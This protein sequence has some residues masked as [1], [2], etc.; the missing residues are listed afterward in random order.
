MCVDHLQGRPEL[1][2]EGAW[3]MM[4]SP[5][6]PPTYQSVLE[7][8]NSNDVVLEIGAGDLRLSHSMALISKQVYAI[9]IQKDIL[10]QHKQALPKNLTIF[11]GDARTINFPPDISVGVILMR[12]CM[13]LQLYAEKLKSSGCKRII[14]NARW[15]LGVEE[16]SL[17]IVRKPYYLLE[18]GWYACWCGAAGFKPGP[19]EH[20]S[21]EMDSIVNEVV[22]CPQCKPDYNLGLLQKAEAVTKF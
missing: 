16:I 9:E 1:Q 15:R 7:K 4:W 8:I 3:E 2:D 12:H 17:E 14:T 21:P 6:D 5:Y 22:N 10:G 13:H 11:H 19:V 18:M 20:F